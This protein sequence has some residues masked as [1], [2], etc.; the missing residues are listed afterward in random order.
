MVI[1]CS[2]QVIYTPFNQLI[3]EPSGNMNITL[4][5]GKRCNPPV[6]VPVDRPSK[7]D[8]LSDSVMDNQALNDDV[9]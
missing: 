1:F 5:P 6:S 4:A 9:S 2:K 3:D 8:A 7:L